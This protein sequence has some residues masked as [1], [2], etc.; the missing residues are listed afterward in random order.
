[1]LDCSKEI[2]EL[3]IKYGADV[4]CVDKSTGT[5]ALQMAIMRGNLTTV[6]LLVNQGSHLNVVTRV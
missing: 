4:N 5:S 2:I 1:M 6:Q 3:L